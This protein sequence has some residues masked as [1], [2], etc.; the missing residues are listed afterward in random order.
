M[1]PPRALFLRGPSPVHRGQFDVLGRSEGVALS[2]GSEL[3]GVAY[4]ELAVRRHQYVPDRRIGDPELEADFLRGLAFAAGGQ[5][6]ELAR[7]QIVVVQRQRLARDRERRRHFSLGHGPGENAEDGRAGEGRTGRGSRV[8]RE[9]DRPEV[10][11]RDGRADRRGLEGSPLSEK[12][13]SQEEQDG[14]Q[15]E[16]QTAQDPRAGDRLDGHH[17]EQ[18]SGL[19]RPQCREARAGEAEERR[20]QVHERQRIV[21]Q[22]SDGSVFAQ[23]LQDLAAGK[24]GE[25]DRAGPADAP[26]HETGAS[27]Q[28]H[29]ARIVMSP[30]CAVNGKHSLMP[31]RWIGIAR[32]EP[33]F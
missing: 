16:G 18:Q 24:T 25:Q 15:R 5:E 10:G 26:A 27:S 9:E 22:L 12:A 7:A 28:L 32:Y 17:G 13:Q 8:G 6:L 11:R 33:G 30:R 23:A 4:A 14:G 1:P 2:Q 3:P 19:H 29:H 31:R 21:E 20:A